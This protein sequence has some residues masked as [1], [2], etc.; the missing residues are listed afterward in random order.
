MP[1]VAVALQLHHILMDAG[2][3]LRAPIGLESQLQDADDL[4]S[5]VGRSMFQLLQA[6]ASCKLGLL[7]ACCFPTSMPS[8]RHCK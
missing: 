6:S 1:P 2:T 4:D 7:L 3:K 8:C 5:D